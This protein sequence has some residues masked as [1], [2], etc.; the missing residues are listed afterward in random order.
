[1]KKYNGIDFPYDYEEIKQ[2]KPKEVK[3]FFEWFVRQIPER[4]EILKKYVNNTTKVDFNYSTKSLIS[5]WEWF[6]PEIIIVEKSEKEKEELLNF[7]RSHAPEYARHQIKLEDDDTRNISDYTRSIAHDIG[8]YFAETI[9][10]NN[11]PLK[12]GYITKPKSLLFVNKPAVV[13]F[14]NKKI[15][16]P[17]WIIEVMVLR[18]A[19]E[20]E[21]ERLYNLY[22]T[23]CKYIQ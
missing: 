6:E 22:E 14:I 2:L 15:M 7:L 3:A 5:L 19:R 9:I 1:M 11:E 17:L 4:L 8:I 18:S 16:E 21:K 20:K 13:G 10:R 12:W 23:W